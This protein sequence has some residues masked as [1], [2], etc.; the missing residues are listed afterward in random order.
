MAA[1]K[2]SALTKP[3]FAFLNS[4]ACQ[5]VSPYNKNFWPKMTDWLTSVS[6]Q[7]EGLPKAQNY[8][9]A[10]EPYL[11]QRVYMTADAWSIQD[12]RDDR[13]RLVLRGVRLTNVYDN[14]VGAAPN[15][16]VDHMNIWVSLEW[17]NCVV[18][19]QSDPLVLK[20]VLYEYVSAKRTRNIGVLPVLLTPRSRKLGS[21]WKNCAACPCTPLCSDIAA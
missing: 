7:T 1:N 6:K 10:L 8:R 16:T 17:F 18:P 3:Q 11:F 19:A 9:C 20:G 2:T 21:S 14:R 13:I 15:I 5:D 12:I 4:E